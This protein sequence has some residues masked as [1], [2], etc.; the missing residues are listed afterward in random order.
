[1]PLHHEKETLLRLQTLWRTPITPK[2]ILE[3]HVH[4]ASNTAAWVS[5]NAA[6]ATGLLKWIPFHHTTYKADD[7][8]R[9]MD[10]LD[11]QDVPEFQ[12]SQEMLGEEIEDAE[13]HDTVEVVDANWRTS[14]SQIVIFRFIY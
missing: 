3:S 4:Q 11:W 1:M 12:G 2:H 14:V 8:T 5:G 6:A 13:G 7:L 9:D 10:A